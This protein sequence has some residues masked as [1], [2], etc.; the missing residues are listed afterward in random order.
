MGLRR[1][2]R[3]RRRRKE[4]LGDGDRGLRSV[5]VG[6][7]CLVRWGS[8][9]PQRGRTREDLA[10]ARAP[11]P[12]WEPWPRFAHNP[13]RSPLEILC[14]LLFA[15]ACHLSLILLAFPPCFVHFWVPI[16]R[17]RRSW[18][19]IRRRCP[20]VQI[21]DPDTRQSSDSHPLSHHTQPKPIYGIRGP[22]ALNKRTS[23]N[24]TL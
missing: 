20:R 10:P 22:A 9:F 14:T 12:G 16:A 11:R 1:P 17:I 4:L 6:A 5:G 3:H 8:W 15:L 13:C 24:K 23:H 21:A 7:D 2:R 19:R 18:L